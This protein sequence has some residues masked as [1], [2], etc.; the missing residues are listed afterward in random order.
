M[1]FHFATD[2]VSGGPGTADPGTFR[3]SRCSLA[4]LIIKAFNLQ[5]YQLPGRSSLPDGTFDIMA[6]IPPG[7]TAGDFSAMLQNLLKDRF[8]LMWHFQEKKLKGYH[9]V[10]A[11]N[12]PKLEAST[13]T[14]QRRSGGAESHSHNGVIAFGTTA[15]FRAANQTIADLVRILSD[16]TGLPVDDETGLSGKYDIALRWTGAAPANSG[17]HTE[18][19]FSEHAHGGGAAGGPAVDPSGPTLFDALQEQLGLKLVPAEQAAARL[20]VVDRIAPRPTE[21]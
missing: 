7:A 17:A 1:G 16:Q 9:L 2:A 20:F 11:K 18:G 10:V 15:N 12:G 14:G 3:C 4:T 6:K 8:G 19:A 13:D 21:N 5:P